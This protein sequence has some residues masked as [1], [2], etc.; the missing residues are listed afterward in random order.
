MEP[1]AA[2]FFIFLEV[3]HDVLNPL[4]LPKEQKLLILTDRRRDSVDL[5]K[6]QTDFFHKCCR[7]VTDLLQTTEFLFCVRIVGSVC[8]LP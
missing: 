8:T 3:P 5:Q 1:A 4:K 6:T 2:M 7:V